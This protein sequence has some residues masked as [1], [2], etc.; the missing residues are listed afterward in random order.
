MSDKPNNKSKIR[1][2]KPARTV[3]ASSRI[4]TQIREAIFGGVLKPGDRIGSEMELASQFDVSRL[5]VRDALK[6][7]EALGCVEIRVGSS[8]GALVAQGN[9]DKFADALAIQL[10]LVGVTEQEMIVAQLAVESM[11][12]ELAAGHATA[13]D[14]AHLSGLLAEAAGRLDDPLGFTESSLAFHL[15]VAEASH[16]RILVAQLKALRYVEWSAYSRRTTRKIAEGVMEAHREILGLIEE[17]DAPGARRAMSEHLEGIRSRAYSL[18]EEA[19]L[20][21]EDKMKLC[22]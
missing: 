8:G 22:C 16:N 18:S 10:K 4:V 15:A 14:L 17:R 1:L 19:G 6:T 20:A 5:T 7:L 11:T 21:G 3:S 9:P 2:W 12:A 13:E